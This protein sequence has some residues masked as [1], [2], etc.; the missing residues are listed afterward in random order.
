MSWGPNVQDECGQTAH[1]KFGK[2][3]E[4]ERSR[5]RI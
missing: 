2:G 5:E 3:E 1:T 4:P